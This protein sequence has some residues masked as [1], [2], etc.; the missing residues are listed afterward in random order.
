MMVS[1][2]SSEETSMYMYVHMYMYMYMYMYVCSSEETSAWNLAVE[3]GCSTAYCDHDMV[4]PAN[5]VVLWPESSGYP[6]VY[7]CVW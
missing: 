3:M 2:Y 4:I 1:L 7:E 6:Q 5:S